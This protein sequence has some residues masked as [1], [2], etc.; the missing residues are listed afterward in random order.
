MAREGRLL[1]SGVFGG[2]E[3]ID[4]RCSGETLMDLVHARHGGQLPR[5]TRI[6][7]LLRQ[8]IV[9]SFSPLQLSSSTRVYSEDQRS[10]PKSVCPCPARRANLLK[11]TR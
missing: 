10:S 6:A 2:I 1:A 8:E 7:P 9:R 4:L 5:E 3:T 11:G